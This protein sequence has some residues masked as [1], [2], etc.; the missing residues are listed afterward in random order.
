MELFLRLAYAKLPP[1]HNRRWGERKVELVSLTQ[2]HA[3]SITLPLLSPSP[4][5][6]S[7]LMC[8]LEVNISSWISL[9]LLFSHPVSSS[10]DCWLGSMASQLLDK[11]IWSCQLRCGLGSVGRPRSG[12]IL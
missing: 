11:H 9:A 8:G 3:F 1:G 12:V 10:G 5:A 4:D 7:S 6:M 2:E